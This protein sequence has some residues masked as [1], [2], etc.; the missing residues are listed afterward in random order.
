MPGAD[1]R[2]GDE[3]MD[4]SMVGSNVAADREDVSSL[5]DKGAEVREDYGSTGTTRQR[6]TPIEEETSSPD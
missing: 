4:E 2:R 3:S 5:T 6:S 1:E